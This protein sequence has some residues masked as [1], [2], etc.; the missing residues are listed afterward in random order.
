M[1]DGQGADEGVDQAP[2]SARNLSSLVLA[3]RKHRSV[4][5]VSSEGFCCRSRYFDLAP[6]AGRHLRSCW[7]VWCRF[8]ENS[9]PDL[10]HSGAE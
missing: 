2:V 5:A 7:E 3:I 8:L 6:R 9:H 1:A 10:L 4:S